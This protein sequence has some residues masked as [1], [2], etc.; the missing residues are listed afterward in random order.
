MTSQDLTLEQRIARLEAI[1][2]LEQLKY[3]YLRAV[4]AKQYESFKDF[5]TSEGSFNYGPMGHY[6]SPEETTQAFRDG[7]LAVQDGDYVTRQM[8]HAVHPELTMLSDTE[9]T[10]QWMLR[11]RST[12]RA[13][14][15]EMVMCGSYDDRY[16]KVDGQ[17][18]I[19]QQH[20]T[21]L[22]MLMKP[23]TEQAII[24]GVTP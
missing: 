20:F 2:E 14:G 13:Q 11:F 1:Q 12:D 22:W 5:F 3:R 8:H 7:Y 19:Q 15:A 6:Y 16:V 23:L 18:R 21:M 9:A 17:W 10:G 4:D 24:H